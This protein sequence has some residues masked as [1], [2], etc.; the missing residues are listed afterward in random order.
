METVRQITDELAISGQ[1]TIEELPQLVKAG[2]RS[3]VNLRSPKEIGFLDNEQQKI[4]FLELRYISISTPK[5]LTLDDV[6]PVIQQLSEL[7]KPI[8]IHCDSGIRSS[9]VVLMQLAINKGVAAE[10]AFQRVIE[11]GLLND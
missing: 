4:E 8:L 1:P 5:K 10:N 3:V 7:P 6:L 2:Y 11:L 9:I